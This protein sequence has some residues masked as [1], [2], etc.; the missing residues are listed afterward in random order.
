[1]DRIYKEIKV[2]INQEAAFDKFLN[3]LNEW[4]PKAY[5]WS[6]DMLK[7]IRIEG[8]KN[9]LCSEIGPYGFRCD[10][11][12]ITELIEKETIRLKWQI[13]PN[14]VPTPNP[15]KASDLK[16]TFNK[17]EGSA[18][19][20]VLEHFNFQYHGEGAEGYRTMMDSEQGWDYILFCYKKYCE[21]K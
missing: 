5:T 15:D 3:E 17:N 18:T 7:E 10:W 1:M 16:V 14:R 9:G 20:V 11:G 21:K 13:S 2:D 19:T 12:R 8:R 4:W 6:Q